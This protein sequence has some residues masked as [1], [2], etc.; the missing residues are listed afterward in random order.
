MPVI[1]VT[2]VPSIRTAAE[3]VEFATKPSLDDRAGLLFI[4]L[5]PHDLEDPDLYDGNS[6]L[7]SL[8][9]RVVLKIAERASLLNFDGFLRKILPPERFPRLVREQPPLAFPRSSDKK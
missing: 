8:A 5:H 4:N 1:L 6:T 7:A 3:A 2:G 9:N